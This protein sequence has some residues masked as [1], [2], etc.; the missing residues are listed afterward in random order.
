VYYGLLVTIALTIVV[1]IKLV[2]IIL[3]SALIVI[4]GATGLQLSR[5][6]RSV[7]VYS[8]AT[9]VLSVIIGLQL[10]FSLNIASG[11]TI[12]LV[13]FALFLIAVGVSP[14]RTYMQALLARFRKPAEAVPD[15]SMPVHADAGLAEPDAG[16]PGD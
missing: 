10:S 4:P 9:G 1:S 2:G 14:R 3:V 15:E 11:A 8:M 7:I 12:V 5:N 13:M 6:Y 16:T